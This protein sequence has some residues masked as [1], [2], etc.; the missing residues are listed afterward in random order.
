MIK[1]E[2][3]H[4]PVLV[5]QV[6]HYLDPQ[7]GKIY[8]DVTF[9]AGGHTRAIL[10]HQKQ[11]TVIALDWDKKALD[12][13]GIPM[14]EEFGDRL[15]L[16]WGNFALLYKF[17]KNHNIQKVDGILADFGP[18]TIQLKD[19]EGFSFAS[20]TPLDMRMSQ[21][22]Q[23]VTAAQVINEATEQEL[24]DIF[25]QFGQERFSKQIA[26]A[27]VAERK[28]KIILTTA[29]L[30]QLISRVKPRGN[31]RIHVATQTFQALR[32][33]V[34]KELENINSFLIATLD[35]MRPGGRLV[36]ISFHSLE[37]RLVKQFFVEQSR[38]E[39]LV[40]VTK[41]SLM[42][43]DE[44]KKINSSSRSARLRAALFK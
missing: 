26:R 11:C 27:I 8:L 43:S 1:T 3:T 6:L 40:I 32:I 28:Q 19:K 25:W 36:C 13:Y 41:K 34:N 10:E 14:Q 24:R 7:P 17:L 16:L 42:A 33:Y 4:V 18:S 39:R 22:H 23:K 15:I 37:D 20:D 38:K 21:G 35:V 31:K 2:S 44:E 12:D 5:D 29:Q 30:S 9:G